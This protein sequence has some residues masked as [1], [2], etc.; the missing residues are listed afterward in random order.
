M[1]VLSLLGLAVAGYLTWVKL[2]GATP[3][4]AI[5]SG[6]ETVE[7]SRYSEF[8]GFPVAGFGMLGTAA[9]VAGSL[10]WWRRADRRA[11]WL[12]YGIGLASLPI[13]AWLT[14][15]ELFVIHA[16]CIWCVAYAVLV[17][18]TWVVAT[19]ALRAPAPEGRR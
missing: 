5:L 18:A 6:C 2:A 16:V 7:N 17:I 4:C 3:A 14:Y 9:M 12:V 11:L 1:S 8:L 15:L 10:V 19:L 13:I